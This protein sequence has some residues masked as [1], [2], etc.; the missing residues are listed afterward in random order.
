MGQKVKS[1]NFGPLLTT[2][3]QLV[4]LPKFHPDGQKWVYCPL[5]GLWFL[6]FDR[7]KGGVFQL[8]ISQHS[9]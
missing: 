1:Q 6:D 3:L 4:E 8:Q 7:E 2:I 5:D 9:S